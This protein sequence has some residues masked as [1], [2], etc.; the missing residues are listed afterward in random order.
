MVNSVILGHACTANLLTELITRRTPC[1]IIAGV[2]GIIFWTMLAI[3]AYLVAKRQCDLPTFMSMATAIPCILHII[4][5]VVN[6][7]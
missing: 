6:I 5:S 7:L 4:F 2:S 1:G 3:D